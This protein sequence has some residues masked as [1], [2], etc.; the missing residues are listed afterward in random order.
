LIDNTVSNKGIF[1]ILSTISAGTLLLTISMHTIFRAGLFVSL[2]GLAVIAGLSWIPIV[3]W[4]VGSLTLVGSI[5]FSL[6]DVIGIW[7]KEEAKKDISRGLFE[8]FKYKKGDILN[9]YHI[10]FNKIIKDF[11]EVIKN[12]QAKKSQFNDLID[13]VKKNNKK[14]YPDLKFDF[15]HDEI[16]EMISDKDLKNFFTDVFEYNFDE[17][18]EN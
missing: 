6:R 12:K 4:I 1:V 9:S 2:E 7:K 14:V 17:G 13:I 15:I 5:I 10:T 16:K 3:G 8:W 18:V 11:N